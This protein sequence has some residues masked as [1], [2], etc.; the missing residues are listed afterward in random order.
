MAKSQMRSKFIII[1][2]CIKHITINLL[3]FGFLK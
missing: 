2:M 3:K 1:I